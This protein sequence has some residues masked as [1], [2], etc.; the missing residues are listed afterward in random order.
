VP[1]VAT[2]DRGL[3]RKPDSALGAVGGLVDGEAVDIVTDN[4]NI[5]VVRWLPVVSFVAGNP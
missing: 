3:H 5:D 2:A 1:R 4:E